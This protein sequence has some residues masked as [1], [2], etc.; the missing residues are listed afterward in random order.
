[1]E[2]DGHPEACLTRGSITLALALATLTAAG[3]GSARSA[4]SELADSCK[5]QKA[6]IAAVGPIDGLADAEHALRETLRIERA[7][8]A[9]VRRAESGRRLERERALASRL[10]AAVAQIERVRAS[11]EHADPTQTMAPLQLGPTAAR[12][13]VENAR[14]LA[15]ATCRLAA[16]GA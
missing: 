2:R 3:C 12:R 16:E 6:G 13:A 8:L 4:H 1:V 11:I 14:R 5:R 7:A 15:R 10:H 9:D